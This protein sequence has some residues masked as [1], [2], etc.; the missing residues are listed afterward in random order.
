MEK[1]KKRTL[2]PG[3]RKERKKGVKNNGFQIGATVKTSAFS[4][5]ATTGVPLARATSE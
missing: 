2:L 5:V 4:A 1:C 3:D